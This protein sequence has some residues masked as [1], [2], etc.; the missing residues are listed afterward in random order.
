[1]VDSHSSIMALAAHVI[2]TVEEGQTYD[3]GCNHP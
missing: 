3:L 1:M 2:V